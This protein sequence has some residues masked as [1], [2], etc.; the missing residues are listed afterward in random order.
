MC[1]IQESTSISG[2][3]LQQVC[4]NIR[5]WYLSIIHR[6]L[7]CLFKSKCVSP[8]KQ[9]CS[10][11]RGCWFQRPCRH[12]PIFPVWLLLLNF[13]V[14]GTNSVHPSNRLF[15][16]LCLSLFFLFSFYHR[17][18][19]EGVEP[20]PADF[21]QQ[22]SSVYLNIFILDYMLR[23]DISSVMVDEWKLKLCESRSELDVLEDS[24]I[25]QC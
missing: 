2:I 1:P 10:S 23:L 20:V 6:V 12:R 14:H 4:A 13:G 5:S 22:A 25:P 8:W 3:N 24:H 18:T 21:E 19:W 15:S 16:Y 11:T 17:V 7:L 9:P